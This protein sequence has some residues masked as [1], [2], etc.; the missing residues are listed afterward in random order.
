MPRRGLPPPGHINNDV[1]IPSIEIV[2]VDARGRICLPSYGR[3]HTAWLIPESGVIRL[4]MVLGPEPMIEISP[5]EHK[6][7]KIDSEI[8]NSEEIERIALRERHLVSTMESNGRVQL[9]PLALFHLG[10]DQQHDKVPVVF[11][12]DRVELWSATYR[13][14]RLRNFFD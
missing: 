4:L 14:E 11:Y 7:E 6:G 8:S 3:S 12:S 2:S 10:L 5:W 1:P 9:P 13:L